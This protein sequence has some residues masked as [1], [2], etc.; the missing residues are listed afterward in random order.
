MDITTRKSRTALLTAW[1]AAAAVYSAPVQAEQASAKGIVK[2]MYA[3]LA[4]KKNLSADIDMSLDVV[5]PQLETIT[6]DASGS[7]LVARPNNIR[8]TRKGGYADIELIS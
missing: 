7:V 3:Y 4:R 5:T 2:A 1:V 8:A 6:F